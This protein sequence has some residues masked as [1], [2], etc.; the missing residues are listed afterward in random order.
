MSDTDP[1]RRAGVPAATATVAGERRPL[2]GGRSHVGLRRPVLDLLPQQ[3]RPCPAGPSARA[4]RCRRG[5]GRCDRGMVTA[6]A[7]VALPVLFVVLALAV[8]ALAC[9]SAQLRCVDAARAAARLAARGETPGVVLAAGRE[10][11]PRGAS[12]STGRAGEQVVVTVRAE[13]RP[14][15]GALRALPAVSVS[16]RAAALREE[17]LPEPTGSS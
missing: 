2:L 12:I 7:A 16:A 14:F 3:R 4:A 10:A 15:G 8:W 11:G 9:V 17:G 6:E 5:C 13:V 1:R